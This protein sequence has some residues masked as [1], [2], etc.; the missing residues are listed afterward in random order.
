MALPQK[1]RN[2]IKKQATNLLEKGSRFKK[3]DQVRQ[4]HFWSMYRFT[5]DANGFLASG[6]FDIFTTPSGQ[7][8][9]GFTTALGL[10]ETNWAGVNRVPDN[11]NIE[12]SELGVS[13]IQVNTAD[14]RYVSPFPSAIEDEV[15]RNLILSIQYLTNQVPLGLC[16]DFAQA[17]GPQ[18][19]EYHPSVPNGYMTDAAAPPTVSLPLNDASEVS[20]PTRATFYTNGFAAPGLRR[21]F[22]IPI[23]L[24]HGETFKFVYTMAP[25]RGPWIGANVVVDVRMDFWATE[26]FVEKS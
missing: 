18:V 6:D 7:S 20:I 8:G 14:N 5:A 10:R 22:K 24:Q 25:G 21:R 11:Q 26:S 4:R 17:S 16:V 15:L 13:A 19:G 23:L 2:S 12:L 9:Q 1:I 3:F